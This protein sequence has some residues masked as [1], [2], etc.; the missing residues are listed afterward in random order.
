MSNITPIIILGMH[1]SGTSCLAGCLQ[2]SGVYLGN[3]STE[4][5]F[6]PKGNREN[7]LI[8]ELNDEILSYND[9][10]WQSPPKNNLIWNESHQ[11]R[12]KSLINTFETNSLTNYWGFKDPR[13]IFTLEF[14]LN[15]LNNPILVGSVRHPS[16][17]ALS[18]CNRDSSYTYKEGLNLWQ[19]YNL[20]MLSHLTR[21]PFPLISF[22]L[23]KN[24]YLEQ[25]DSIKNLIGLNSTSSDHFF[26]PKL[27]SNSTEADQSLPNDILM[28]YQQLENYYFKNNF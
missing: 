20:K 12:A 14:W 9:A 6:N 28:C 15:I 26:D 7:Q 24:D 5:K 2:E 23:D 27:R 21:K 10:T 25:I 13:S 18:L 11:L 17:V 8:M 1:R 22:D 3:V 16:K 4:N 19:S